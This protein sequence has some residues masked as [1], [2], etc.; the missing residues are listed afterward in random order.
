TGADRVRVR[1]VFSPPWTTEWISVEARAKLK[2]YGISPPG[3]VERDTG[4]L[5]PLRRRTESPQCPFCDSRRTE[6]RSEF[7]STACKSIAYCNACH[8]PFELFKAI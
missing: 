8:Q 4:E 7:G 5:V 2:A 6:L 3:P 1:T